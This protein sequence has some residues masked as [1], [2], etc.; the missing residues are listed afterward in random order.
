MDLISVIVPIYRVEQYLDTCIKSITGQSYSNL[1][2]ILVD[3]GSPDRCPEMCDEWAKKDHRVKVIHKENGGLSDARNTGLDIATGKY[4]AFVDSDDWIEENYISY[5]HQVCKE[6]KSDVVAC[7]IRNVREDKNVLP[8][9]EQIKKARI[10]TPQEAIET[11]LQDCD[12][13]AV[14]WNKLYRAEILSN[15]KFEIGRLHEDEFFTYR[16]LDKAKSLAF[17]DI[18]LYNYRQREGSIMTTFSIRHLDALDAY[19]GRIKLFRKKYY[20]L[21]LKDK[22][23]FCTSCINFYCDT[24]KKQCEEQ[25]VAQ[26]KIKE[27]RG[28]ICFKAKDLKKY[29]LKE[30]VYIICSTRWLIGL[31]CRFRIW[32]GYQ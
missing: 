25:K 19:L 31:F 11:I 20:D 9:T 10:C 27:L 2:I 30:L 6:T 3:D 22:V 18:P 14:A 4:V 13:R 28:E 32:R 26:C 24:I 16:I 5:L 29:S 8:I 7:G 15:E 23:A 1:E 12:F 21:Y 17:L